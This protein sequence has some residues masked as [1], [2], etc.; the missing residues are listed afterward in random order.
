MRLPSLENWRQ[1][2]SFEPSSLIKNIPT[3]VRVH[4]HIT[5]PLPMAE[6]SVLI[7]KLDTPQ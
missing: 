6:V 1:G 7:R 2:F 3:H 5:V 4:L